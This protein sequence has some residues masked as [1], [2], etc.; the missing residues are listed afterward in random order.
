MLKWNHHHSINTGNLFCPYLCS[1][2]VLLLGSGGR[3]HALA[4]KI[5]RSPQCDRLFIAPGNPG[6]ATCGTN[7]AIKATDFPALTDFCLQQQINMVVVGPEDPLVAGVVDH[8]KADPAV[9]HIPVIGPNKQAAQLEGSKAFAKAFMLR[10][11]VQTPAYATFTA[12]DKVA[13][14]AYLQQHTLPVVLKAD[15]LAAG[16]GVVICETTAAAISEF[17]QMVSGKFGNAGNTVVVEQFLTGI[18]LTVIVLTDGNTYCILPP[19]KDYKRVG[20]GDTGLN[21]GGMGAV[22]PPPF[23]TDAFMEKVRTKIIDPTMKGLK[24]EGIH[25]TGFLYFGLFNSNGD[26][27]VIEY[28]CRMGDPETQVIMPRI[29]SDIITL[30]TAVA[31]GDLADHPL[32]TDPRACSTVILASH[33]YPGVFEKGYVITG[34]ENTEDCMVFQAGTATNENGELITAGGRVMAVSAY[35]EDIAAALRKSYV[36]AGRIYYDSRYFRR[37]IGW[38]M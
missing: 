36:N 35:G 13:A 27:Y 23:A 30:F 17:D 38:D 18:E 28:N 11:H 32:E 24:N 29:A 22:S 37:D 2:N 26:P 9:A 14:H 25:Y 3:E 16:K 12:A 8:F 15:G 21:T 7:V 20:D 4:W 19:S 1:M 10:N 31:N 5:S 6:T 33:G 34:I